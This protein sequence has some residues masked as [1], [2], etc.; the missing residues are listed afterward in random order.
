[1]NGIPISRNP[2]EGE[3]E[4]ATWE[5]GSAWEPP[6]GWAI[7]RSSLNPVFICSRLFVAWGFYGFPG[8]RRGL[9]NPSPSEHNGKGPACCRAALSELH[10]S[11]QQSWSSLGSWE[12]QTTLWS[13]KVMAQERV[14]IVLSRIPRRNASKVSGICSRTR[15]EVLKS[16][17]ESKNDPRDVLF[18]ISI[19]PEVPSSFHAYGFGLVHSWK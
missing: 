17:E 8:I 14:W 4:P 5:V 2:G 10:C 3:S 6:A 7:L 15:A 13:L 16:V 1:M 18:I 19:N 11:K 9:E 12:K